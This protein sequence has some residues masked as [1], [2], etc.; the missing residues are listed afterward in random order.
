MK[1]LKEYLDSFIVEFDWKDITIFKICL[2]AFGVMIG[3]SLPR[4]KKKSILAISGAV[5]VVS[6]IVLLCG[7]FDVECPFCQKDE[8]FDFDDEDEDEKGLVMKISA[9]D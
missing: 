4:K 9:E 5:F 8:G 3:V 1:R 2:T 7:L 6:T